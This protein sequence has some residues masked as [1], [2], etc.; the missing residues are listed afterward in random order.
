[1]SQE[2]SPQVPAPQTHHCLR[3]ALCG[4]PVP[5]LVL[6]FGPL[7]PPGPFLLLQHLSLLALGCGHTF[8]ALPGRPLFSLRLLPPGTPLP[9]LTSQGQGTAMPVPVGLAFPLPLLSRGPG[10]GLC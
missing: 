8:P 1:M 2:P 6:A 7:S 5:S 3:L 9:P 10:L 4:H